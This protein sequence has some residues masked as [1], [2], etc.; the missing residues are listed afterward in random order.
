[1]PRA[2]GKSC[3][4]LGGTCPNLALP[5]HARCADHEKSKGRVDG[6]RAR[7]PWDW[8]WHDVRWKR[9]ARL[10]LIEEPNC[11]ICGAPS[12]VA[13]H[14]VELADGGAPF[15]RTNT[16]GLCNRDNVSKGQKAAQARRQ[17]EQQAAAGL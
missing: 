5:G 12:E 1:M 17:R 6:P 2:S 3:S 4:A 7:N 11:R 16:Q 14:I 15:A 10:T 13:D 8:V 9:L